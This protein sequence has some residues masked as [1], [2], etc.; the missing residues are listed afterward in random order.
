MVA[1]NPAGRLCGPH[2]LPNDAANLELEFAE[3]GLDPTPFRLGV[4]RIDPPTMKCF[5]G[6]EF[7]DRHSLSIV[8]NKTLVRDVARYCSR[9]FAHAF[10]HR[11]IFI[12]HAG[13]H[14]SAKYSD[15][16]QI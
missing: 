7:D 3:E 16:H 15:D 14:S 2:S 8:R 4:L 10:C 9:K 1:S 6:L 11:P 5:L 12:L 13:I